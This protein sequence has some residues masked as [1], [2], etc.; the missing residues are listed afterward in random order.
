MKQTDRVLQYCQEYGSI[1][2]R[3]AMLDIGIADL[4]G[5]IRDL[6]KSG[7]T[8][9]SKWEK[10]VNRYGDKTPYKRYYILGNYTVGGRK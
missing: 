4:Q 8:I 1:T 3:T 10:G 7:F 2:T 9:E 5:V 6:K